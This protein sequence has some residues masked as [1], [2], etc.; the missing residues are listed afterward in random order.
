[1]CRT[2]LKGAH[3]FA[4]GDF[5]HSTFMC[6]ISSGL[7]PPRA[8]SHRWAGWGSPSHMGTENILET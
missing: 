1:M 5:F 6:Q 4:V 8:L 7:R 3:S 2:I